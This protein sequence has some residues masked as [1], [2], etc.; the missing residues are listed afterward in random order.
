MFR[1]PTQ[2]NPKGHLIL[3]TAWVLVGLI[4]IAGLAV[5]SV[6]S[7]ENFRLVWEPS[8]QAYRDVFSSGRW[9]V[10]VRTIRVAAIVT[11]LVSIF[12]FPFA[13]W[14]AKGTRSMATKTILLGLLTVPFFLSLSARTIIW[15]GLL[16]LNGPVN[17]LLLQLGVVSE[18]LD[19]LLFSEFAVVLG[20]IAPYFP[21]MVFPLYMAFSLIDDEVLDASRDLGASPLFTIVHVVLPLA[22]PGIGAGFVFTFIPMIGDPVVPTLLGGGNVVVLAESVQSLLRIL[23]YTVAAALSVLMLILLI[24]FIST[25][26]WLTK[27]FTGG[28]SNAIS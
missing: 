3:L 8:L 15:R 4:P 22:I 18:P 17:G 28:H 5:W 14:M 13:Y 20:L 12:A 24:G 27:R 1:S 6:L 25:A 10:T 11:V 23:N 16:G 7:M 9:E 21:T 19:W 2:V 26:A